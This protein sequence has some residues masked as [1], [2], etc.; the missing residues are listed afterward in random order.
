MTRLALCC[1]VALLLSLLPAAEAL[2]SPQQARPRLQPLS[3]WGRK[4]QPEPPAAPVP[5]PKPK[6]S[7]LS[8]SSIAQLVGF[9]AGTPVLGEFE[10][11][12]DQGRAIFKLEANNLV[13]SKGDI[14]QTRAKFFN[15]G[16][17]ESSDDAIKPPG[18]WA[19]LLSGGK[20]QAEWDE[21]NRVSK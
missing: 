7:G 11:F 19:N 6:S 17:T 20:L 18:F 16:W 1:A 13:D 15:Q 10:K 5:P 12:D 14:I 4:K 9:G 21:A 3:M 2:V 8:L